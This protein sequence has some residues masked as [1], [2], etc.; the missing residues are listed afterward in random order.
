MSIVNK[1]ELA[2]LHDVSEETLS[3]WQGE[4]MPVLEHGDRGRA[5]QYDTGATIRW[6]IDRAKARAGAGD[7]VR[8]RRDQIALDREQLALSKLK[9]QLVPADQVEPIWHVRALATAAFMASRHSRLAALLQRAPD[10]E[11]KRRILK[12]SDVAFLNVLGTHGD[13]IQDAF[14]RFLSGLPEREAACL[15]SGCWS[16]T[17]GA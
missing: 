15:T 7:P 4:G 8:E 13:A 14:E 12:E 9:A 16:T 17:K 11:A 1:A 2:R 3:R 6:R 10:L 5:N